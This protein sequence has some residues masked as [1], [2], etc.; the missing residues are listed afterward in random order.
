MHRGRAQAQAL[1]CSFPSMQK[2]PGE[3]ESREAAVRLLWGVGEEVA[4]MEEERGS[5][6][7]LKMCTS[8]RPVALSP[9]C[10]YVTCPPVRPQLPLAAGRCLGFKDGR[11]E[12][13]ESSPQVPTQGGQR[14]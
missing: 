12:L 3:C 4:S 8:W 9:P 7:P 14:V 5:E 2:V 1:P 10:P 11:R 13:A 6:R